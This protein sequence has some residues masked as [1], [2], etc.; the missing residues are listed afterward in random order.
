M[1]NITKLKADLY[2]GQPTTIVNTNL[3]LARACGATDT[4]LYL[5]F[6]PKTKA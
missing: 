1:A 3:K 5:N 6:E 4:T 2:L